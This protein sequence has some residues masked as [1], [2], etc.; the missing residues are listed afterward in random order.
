MIVECS[1]IDDWW[2]FCGSSGCGSIL[3]EYF[4][5]SGSK[6]SRLITLVHEC[7]C[8][9]V[10]LLVLLLLASVVLK[11]IR[12]SAHGGVSWSSSLS[13]LAAQTV[14]VVDLSL[15]SWANYNIIRLATSKAPVNC[16]ATPDAL[17]E[18]HSYVFQSEILLLGSGKVTAALPQHSCYNTSRTSIVMY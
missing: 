8:V 6:P 13:I 1:Q 18:S 4:E 2:N 14:E 11:F 15:F 12:R 17:K 10:L 16:T 3:N 5:L 7:Y 9:I